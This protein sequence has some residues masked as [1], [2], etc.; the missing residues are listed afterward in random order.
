MFL[1]TCSKIRVLVMC[2]NMVV[3]NITYIDGHLVAQ[4]R[5]LIHES[6]LRNTM[7]MGSGNGYRKPLVVSSKYLV[8]T[9][10][11]CLVYRW[12]SRMVNSYM[13]LPEKR[14]HKYII[15]WS[16]RII[17][18]YICSYIVEKCSSFIMFRHTS[19]TR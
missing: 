12:Q 7:R 13:T 14:V 8:Y 15:P 11:Q 4:A 2:I 10:L 19:E 1:P 9:I 6:M 18:C 3:W 17:I 16:I 5:W